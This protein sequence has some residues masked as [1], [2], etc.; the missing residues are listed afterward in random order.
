[1]LGYCNGQLI[2]TPCRLSC[3]EWDILHPHRH[4]RIFWRQHNSPIDRPNSCQ[5]VA[6]YS[7]L[8]GTA[9]LQRNFKSSIYCQGYWQVFV[10][11]CIVSCHSREKDWGST[12][13]SSWTSSW[14]FTLHFSASR[15][16][17]LNCIS[18]RTFYT[19]SCSSVRCL[20]L[21]RYMEWCMILSGHAILKVKH[22]F[23]SR[24][25]DVQPTPK[26]LRQ[27]LQ[28]ILQARILV[29]SPHIRTL[30]IAY[31]NI[32]YGL[33]YLC[34]WW[35][36][37]SLAHIE[38]DTTST[39]FNGLFKISWYPPSDSICR[40]VDS[41][42]FLSSCR[43][44]LEFYTRRASLDPLLSEQSKWE[45]AVDLST[46]LQYLHDR[47]L[48]QSID[49][50]I[51]ATINAADQK[52]RHTLLFSASNDGH[53]SKWLSFA[54]AVSEEPFCFWRQLKK[55]LLGLALWVPLCEAA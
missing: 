44:T 16:S 43:P 9:L 50:L 30:L 13:S 46:K 22:T 45:P 38:P 21:G 2:P 14:K 39:I 6:R 29:I 10:S 5:C 4:R 54:A 31:I 18:G 47:V 3:L 49:G 48:Y 41:A 15:R 32:F 7:R 25:E 36:Y 1:M 33:T 51:S 35:R 20:L 23:G 12:G 27:L 53:I 17:L 42:F 11:E 26:H 34:R 37:K 52:T 19:L 24:T 40:P 55:N 8:P 28:E